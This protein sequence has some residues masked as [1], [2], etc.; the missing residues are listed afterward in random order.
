MK[1]SAPVYIF[2]AKRSPI[3]R[4]GGQFKDLPAIE[5]AHQVSAAILPTDDFPV[6]EVVAG[7]VIQAGVGMN[8]ARQ[9]SLRLGLPKEI[10]AYTVN[11]VCGSGLKAIGMAAQDIERKEVRAALALGVE[12][13]SR[14][15]Y[16]AVQHRWG[17]RYGDGA[18]RDA[19]LSDALTDPVTGQPMGDWAEIIARRYEVSRAHQDAWALRSHQRATEATP[20]FERE[21]VP[22]QTKRGDVK[23]D[24]HVRADANLETL[25]SLKTVFFQ[26]GSVTAGNAAGLNDG[27]AALLLGDESLCGVLPPRARIAGYAAVGCDPEITGMGPVGAIKKLCADLQWDWREVPAVEINEAFASQTLACV[28]ELELDPE[29]VNQRGG[30]IALGHPVGCSGARVLVTLLHLME[31]ANYT[32]GLAALC[33]GGGM[34]IAMAIELC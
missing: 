13:M 31:D 8:I 24:E 34:G 1:F 14:A 11:M 28:R 26:S 4:L 18:L 16:L 27:A 22:I 15:P 7:Q 32:R 17:A 21:I 9:V 20:Q 12:S 19:I 30:G 2:D 23:R 25:A 5:L 33:V 10:A 29:K 3:G 6:G